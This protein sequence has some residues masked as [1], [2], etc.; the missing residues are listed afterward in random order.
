[1]RLLK[2]ISLKEKIVL[3]VE[4]MSLQE[5]GEARRT[6]KNCRN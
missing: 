5:D 4:V 6:G 2:E 1:M 3:L